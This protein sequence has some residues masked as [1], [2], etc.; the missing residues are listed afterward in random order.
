VHYGLN[1]SAV[2]NT[3]IT[4]PTKKIKKSMRK[5]FHGRVHN[6]DVR[7][8]EHL[9]RDNTANPDN[10]DD[11]TD[12]NFFIARQQLSGGPVLQSIVQQGQAGIKADLTA[13]AVAQGIPADQIAFAFIG[14]TPPGSLAYLPG[15]NRPSSRGDQFKYW[16]TATWNIIVQNFVMGGTS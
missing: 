3:V 15:P 13:D 11:V 8:F 6:F 12:I 14:D 4:Y 2:E 7:R 16:N 9:L 5:G 10:P 1:F